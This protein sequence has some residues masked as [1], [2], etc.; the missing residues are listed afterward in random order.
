MSLG[1]RDDYVA[2]LSGGKNAPFILYFS[3]RELRRPPPE[4]IDSTDSSSNDEGSDELT[5][6]EV[7]ANVP[8]E[9]ALLSLRFVGRL[10]FGFVPK[11]EAAIISTFQ[12]S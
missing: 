7:L 10:K 5:P 4:Y 6:S 12:V 1:L 2:D 9:L 11:S 8:P 3:A